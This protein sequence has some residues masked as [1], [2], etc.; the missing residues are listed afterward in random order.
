MEACPLQARSYQLFADVYYSMGNYELSK[1]YFEQAF[2]LAS[3]NSNYLCGIAKC[4]MSS[5]NN[6]AAE[7]QL[8][9]AL[10]LCKSP[11]N[12]IWVYNLMKR[13]KKNKGQIKES[14]ELSKLSDKYQ[15]IFR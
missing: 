11:I 5:G 8:E 10:E 9:E 7:E 4:E 13:C 12:Y 6:S 14:I 15:Q 3:N 1:D 2:M